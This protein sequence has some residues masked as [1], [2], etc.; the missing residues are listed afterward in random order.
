MSDRTEMKAR[1]T[2]PFKVYRDGKWYWLRFDEN[3]KEILDEG[4]QRESD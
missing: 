2:G 4:P 3:G 1:E